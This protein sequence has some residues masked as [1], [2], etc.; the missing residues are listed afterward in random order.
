MC[1]IHDQSGQSPN[2]AFT[3]VSESPSKMALRNPNS[4][5]K[6]I[7]LLAAIASR[8]STVFNDH[9]LILKRFPPTPFPKRHNKDFFFFENDIT[10]T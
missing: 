6:I 1:P 4:S 5:M 2:K 8:I 7:A 10:K 3:T 9:Y